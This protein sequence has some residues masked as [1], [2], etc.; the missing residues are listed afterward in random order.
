M[1]LQTSTLDVDTQQVV[2][3]GKGGALA[4]WTEASGFSTYNADAYASRYVP[5]TGWEAPV[6]VRTTNREQGSF[7]TDAAMDAAGNAVVLWSQYS[8]SGY[9]D[10]LYACRYVAGQGWRAPELLATGIDGGSWVS[11]GDI[12][13]GPRVALDPSG[14]GVVAWRGSAG[15]ILTRWLQ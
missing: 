13:A 6:L 12:Y 4:I 8:T 11:Y 7:L 1:K 15:A 3:D 14:A 2:T 9:P 10:T 5:G